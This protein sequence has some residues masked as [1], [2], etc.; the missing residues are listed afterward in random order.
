VKLVAF[1]VGLCIAAVGAVGIVAPSSLV[2]LAQHFMTSG[3]FYVIAA[4][5][6]VFG[7]ILISVAPSSRTPKALRVLATS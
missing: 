2:W 4:V 3:P 1:V 5:R 6:I 7:L